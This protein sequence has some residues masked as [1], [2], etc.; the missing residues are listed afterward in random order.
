MDNGKVISLDQARILFKRMQRIPDYGL[1]VAELDQAII[2]TFALL[3]M[4]NL[5][6]RG[7]CSGVLEDLVV[8]QAHQRRGIGT[9]LNGEALR[10]SEAKGCY[11]LTLSS[12]LHRTGAHAFYEHLGFTR[13]GYSF[14]IATATG[15]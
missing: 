4:P 5:G 9:F 8:A 1:H 10:R 15:E 3:I 13:H 6:H 11:K 12:N 7:S 2:G 14:S